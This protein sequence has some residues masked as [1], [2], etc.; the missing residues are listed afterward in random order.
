MTAVRSIL[1]CA[2]D[3]D[4]MATTATNDDDMVTSN[5]RDVATGVEAYGTTT[6]W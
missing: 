6:N 1:A 4:D 5:V 3:H 2:A